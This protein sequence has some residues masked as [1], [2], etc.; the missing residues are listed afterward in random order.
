M[1]SDSAGTRSGSKANGITPPTLEPTP[2]SP[3][4]SWANT[5]RTST[6]PTP[7]P[8]LAPGLFAAYGY[9]NPSTDIDALRQSPASHKL[10][11]H[12]AIDRAR[13]SASQLG[14]R[15]R[16][17]AS[18]HWLSR[19]DSPRCCLPLPTRQAYSTPQSTTIQNED[20]HG[21][22]LAHDRWSHQSATRSEE[23][24]KLQGGFSMVDRGAVRTK[25]GE[26]KSLR[27]LRGTIWP[28][29]AFRVNPQ[30]GVACAIRAAAIVPPTL[31]YTDGLGLPINYARALSTLPHLHTV[32]VALPYSPRGTHISLDPT[33]PQTACTTTRLRSS[34]WSGSSGRVIVQSARTRATPAGT[35]IGEMRGDYAASDCGEEEREE[36]ERGEVGVGLEQEPQQEGL[37]GGDEEQK[38]ASGDEKAHARY[39]SELS[40]PTARAP[41]NTSFRFGPH[42]SMTLSHL[43]AGNY[44]HPV[45][46]AH[47]NDAFGGGASANGPTLRV[48]PSPDSEAMRRPIDDA[49]WPCRAN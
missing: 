19:L 21:A 32:R 23:R 34:A 9:D 18:E 27:S 8:T 29:F 4:V 31:I 44:H 46:H 25:E 43:I 45:Y 39:I 1:V 38:H 3:R 37:A 2:M 33:A 24:V 11:L 15:A 17:R 6:R 47:R 49:E 42:T 16:V 7:P 20:R 48:Y 10:D 13:A 35:G 26:A 5:T 28:F 40:M 30:S 12:D 14:C 36:P 41:R 22:V